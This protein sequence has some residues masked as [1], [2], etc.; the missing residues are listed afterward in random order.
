M[1]RAGALF[2]TNSSLTSYTGRHI[3]YYSPE[4]F[5]VLLALRLGE[6]QMEKANPAKAS[7]RTLLPGIYP[8]P[9]IFLVCLKTDALG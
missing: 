1:S 4:Y 9:L 5:L 6:H 3:D 8:T 7:F 2:L